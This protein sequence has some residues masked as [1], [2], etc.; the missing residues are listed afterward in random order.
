[1]SV[2]AGPLNHIRRLGQRKRPQM[3]DAAPVLAAL[4]YRKRI[5]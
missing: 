5:D 2:T 1:M 3:V 4:S